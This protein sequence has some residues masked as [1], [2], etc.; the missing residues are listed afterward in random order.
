MH[1]SLEERLDDALPRVEGRVSLWYKVIWEGE[2]EGMESLGEQ[3][4]GCKRSRYLYQTSR[5]RALEVTQAVLP[6]AP[7]DAGVG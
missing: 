4:I 7:A 2:K 5:M 3:Y 6:A 1:P